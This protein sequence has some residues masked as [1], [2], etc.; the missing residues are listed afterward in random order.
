MMHR[1][2]A[3]AALLALLIPLRA[4]AVPDSGDLQQSAERQEQIRGDARR[5]VARLDEVIAAYGRNG[6]ATGEDFEVLKNVRAML[7][8]LTNEEMEKVVALLNDAAKDAGAKPETAPGQAAQMAQAYAGQKDISLRLKQILAAHEQQQDIDAL[9]NA[10]SKLADRQSANLST[11]IDVKQLAAQDKSANGQTAVTASEE[12]QQAEQSAIAGEVKLVADKLARIAADAGDPKYKDAAGQLADVAPRATDAAGALGAGRIDDAVAAETAAREKL[13]QLAVTLAP[14]SEQDNFASNAAGQ[15][16]G[17][18][19][20]QKALLDKTAQLNAAL[21]AV[22]ANATQEAADKVMNQQMAKSTNLL[23]TKLA[24][25]GITPASPVDQIRNAPD[26]KKFLDARAAAL[27]KQALDIGRQLAALAG[28]QAALATKAQLVR[29]DLEKTVKEAAAPMAN[30]LTQMNTAQGALAQA[31]G[32]QAAQSQSDAVSQ[33]QEAEK[34]AEQSAATADQAQA[35]PAGDRMDQLRQLQNQVSALTAKENASIQQGDA[36]K[37]GPTATA[38]V[39]VQQ[40]LADKTQDMRQAAATADSAAAQPLQ[41]AAA[42]M[43]NA[44]QTM[45]HGGM[46]DIAQSAQQTAV[47]ALG[48]AAQ[49]IVQDILAATKEQHDL[50]ALE[51][52]MQG[53]EKLIHEQQQVN[54]TTQKAIDMKSPTRAK[55][56]A[57]QQGVVHRDTEA[58]IQAVNVATPVLVA[59][60]GQAAAEMDQAVE[61]LNTAGLEPAQPPEKAALA[62]LFQAQD[63][64]AEKIQETAHD[65]GEPQA[66]PQAVANAEAQLAQAGNEVAAAQDAMAPDQTGAAAT[67]KAVGELNQ[68]TLRTAQAAAQPQALPQDARDA[69][70]QAEQAAGEAA[71]AASAGRQPLARQ[72]AGQAQQAIAAAQSALGQM[73]AGVSGLTPPSSQERQESQE[74][75]ESQVAQQESQ[76]QGQIHAAQPS[77]SQA[78]V[79]ANENTWTDPAGAVKRALAGARGAGQYLGL[80]ERDRGALQQSQSEKYPQEYGAMIEEYMR[81]LASDSGGK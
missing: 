27:K 34:L 46:P 5:L 57:N 49:Q 6:I 42:A 75:Q 48:N 69:I 55:G 18:A 80:P 29:E 47:Q 50:A 54:L 63:A 26:M 45:Q 14:A 76:G 77:Q 16:A 51:G 44:A 60:L 71:A 52:E 25:S 12:A 40:N 65:L 74:S 39:A 81:S 72:K 7:G 4:A 67:G 33:L 41:Q 23:A 79:G 1:I 9:A 64:L 2:L 15:L 66:P 53:L 10:V 37:T 22:A 59:P 61:Q 70:R 43:N 78:G 62:A 31:D 17:I 73:Q 58:L 36:Q 68:A 19:Q 20:D 3:A 11:A 21:K 56:L 32:D 24:Q 13:K 28:D 30:A 35:Q 8:S 38:A